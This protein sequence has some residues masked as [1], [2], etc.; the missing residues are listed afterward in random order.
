MYFLFRLIFCFSFFF[1]FNF[2]TAQKSFI[3]ICN[4]W[5]EPV[6]PYF[7]SSPIIECLLSEHAV[8]CC[9]FVCPYFSYLSWI[10]ELKIEN[11]RS[12]PILERTL[13]CLWL[14]G[15]LLLSQ[16]LHTGS[17]QNSVVVRTEHSRAV[18]KPRF[19][20]IRTISSWD[21]S[22]PGPNGCGHKRSASF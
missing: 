6:T 8:L 3:W 13:R 2:P 16:L 4:D 5:H 19:N 11:T 10:L 14:A 22:W 9:M 1:K 17:L 18:D 20:W 15:I 21:D 7:H 12:S